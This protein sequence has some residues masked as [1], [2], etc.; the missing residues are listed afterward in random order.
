MLLTWRIIKMLWNGKPKFD[1]KEIKRVDSPNGR[2]YDINDEKHD[3]DWETT[4]PSFN[5]ISA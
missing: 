5:F 1:Y 3:R 2:V 4:F